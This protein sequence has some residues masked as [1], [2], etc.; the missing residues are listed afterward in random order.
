MA[1]QAAK[2]TAVR[3]ARQWINIFILILDGT[4]S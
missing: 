4:A 2:M 3:R 1:A